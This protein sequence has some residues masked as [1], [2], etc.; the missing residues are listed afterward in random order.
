MVDASGLKKYPQEKTLNH[1]DIN[2][3]FSFFPLI[4]M[5]KLQNSKENLIKQDQIEIALEIQFTLKTPFYLNEKELYMTKKLERILKDK[6]FCDITLI[7]KERRI[8]AHKIV[9]AGT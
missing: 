6:S 1:V 7:A 8:E 2:N 4:S 5:E 9:L 3:G